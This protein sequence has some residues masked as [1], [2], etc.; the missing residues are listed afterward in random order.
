MTRED[1][2]DPDAQGDPVAASE[3]DAP[4]DSGAEDRSRI[5]EH[6]GGSSSSNRSSSPRDGGV[7]D[8]V[9]CDGDRHTGPVRL[10]RSRS[11]DF[12]DHFNRIYE[13][14]GLELK[15]IPGDEDKKIPGSENAAG[16]GDSS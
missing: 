3:P 6:A 9:V 16:D 15:S 2:H 5:G 4:R 11:T 1:E 10:P 8:A 14:L 12:I 13:G 7:C